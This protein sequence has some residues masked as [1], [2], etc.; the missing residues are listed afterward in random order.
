MSQDGHA[1]NLNIL[2]ES[3]N[4]Q[5]KTKVIQLYSTHVPLSLKCKN[6][7]IVICCIH[8]IQQL[9]FV[10]ECLFHE[11]IQ[12][13]LLKSKANVRS[14]IINLI[15]TVCIRTINICNI[16]KLK[17]IRKFLNVLINSYIK[18]VIIIWPTTKLKQLTKSLK[19]LHIYRNK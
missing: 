13:M 11:N 9:I 16:C 15:Q 5:Q 8:L 6:M 17:F 14:K 19:K 10:K 18:T 4:W 3:N 7:K 1:V 2:N 12:K